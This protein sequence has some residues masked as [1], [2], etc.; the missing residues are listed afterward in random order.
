M[1]RFKIVL[2]IFII[3]CLLLSFWG[4]ETAQKV[5]EKTLFNYFDTVSTI[6]S[7]SGDS[8][9]EFSENCRRIRDIFEEYH[10]LF[11]IYNEYE[12][13]NN[14]CTVNKNAG[15]DAL[16]VDRK[17][18]DFLLYTKELYYLTHGEMN[19]MMGSVLTLWRDCRSNAEV[20][21]ENAALP[22]PNLLSAASQFTDIEF[23]EI[24]EDRCTVRI[25]DKKALID[26]GAIGK[27]YATEKAAE[28]L[29]ESGVSGYVLDI[30]G[31][32]RIVGTKPD[33]NGWIT[34]IKDPQD[35][36]KYAQKLML[37]DISCVTS[38][39]YERYF[40]LGGKRYHHIIDKD[41]NMPASFFSS[42]TLICENSALADS[43]ST[44]L[45]CMSYE[46]GMALMKEI[47]EVDV[48]WI[49][50]NGEIYVT[51]GVSELIV[52]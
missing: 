39:D 5:Q 37:S 35:P 52:D 1:K 33:G 48:I 21:P 41:T 8:E 44:A 3:F 47:D 11:D 28:F 51:E 20:D 16:P 49:L 24:D 4:C 36:E 32:I 30:G 34:G 46:E 12:G 14:L 50:P 18:I 43:L 9:A 25:S 27:G 42:V 38:G 26:V 19:V 45:F 7:Y 40:E 31:N 6:Y 2:S 29:K 23:L 22:E 17:L 10:R 13:I 15:G